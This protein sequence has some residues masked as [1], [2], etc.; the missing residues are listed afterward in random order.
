MFGISAN[1]P[2][3]RYDSRGGGDWELVLKWCLEGW[4][5]R[6]FSRSPKQ[7]IFVVSVDGSEGGL[8]H[9]YD[10]L[11]YIRTLLTPGDSANNF[12]N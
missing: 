11:L 10:K 12:L 3:E 4:R 1:Q 9:A 5:T 6:R 7:V 8:T 2:A